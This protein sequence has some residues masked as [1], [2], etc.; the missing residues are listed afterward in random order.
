M[1][2]QVAVHSK[3]GLLACTELQCLYGQCLLQHECRRNNLAPTYKS[4]LIVNAMCESVS[5]RCQAKDVGHCI[6]LECLHIWL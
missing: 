4:C 5:K 3:A 6:V 1:C 2:D